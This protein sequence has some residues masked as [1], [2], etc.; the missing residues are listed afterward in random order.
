MP[1]P[2]I[3]GTNLLAYDLCKNRGMRVYSTSSCVDVH[4]DKNEPVFQARISEKKLIEEEK[5]LKNVIISFL[6]VILFEDGER[7]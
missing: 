1:H 7:S 6:S 5:E 3:K 4:F 2:P